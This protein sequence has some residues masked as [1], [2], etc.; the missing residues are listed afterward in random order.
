MKVTTRK[1]R[2]V[3]GES[4]V[5]PRSVTIRLLGGIESE[6][7]KKTNFDRVVR[8]VRQVM[9][10][11]VRKGEYEQ[12]PLVEGEKDFR[13]TPKTKV[14]LSLKQRHHNRHFR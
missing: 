14:R 1:V 11:M 2:K 8:H 13:Y 6:V 4:A 9:K 10:K 12:V 5:T 7:T 3:I